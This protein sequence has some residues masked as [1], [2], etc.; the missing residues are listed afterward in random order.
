MFHLNSENQAWLV[1]PIRTQL[2]GSELICFSAIN[3]GP[4][5]I[6]GPLWSFGGREPACHCKTCRFSPWVRKIPWGRKWQPTPVFL[7]GKS[8]GQWSLV[9]YIVHGVT[10]SRTWLSDF[11]FTFY[12]HA[13]EKDMA[14][15]STVLAWRIPGTGSLAG[16]RLWGRTESD[17]TGTA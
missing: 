16:C 17:T 14:T 9:G 12:F 11:T 4:E 13:L 5:M 1:S 10:K 8:K 7:P 3:T 2:R 15:H 6:A